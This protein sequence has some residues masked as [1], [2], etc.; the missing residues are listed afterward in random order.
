MEISSMSLKITFDTAE[1]CAA[2]ATLAKITVEENAVEI[3]VPWSKLTMAKQAAGAVSFEQVNDDNVEFIMKGDPEHEGVA[4]LIVMVDIL[5]NDFYH[6]K[7]TNALALF[8]LV[9]GLDP[10][11]IDSIALHG[12]SSISA[13]DPDAVD[14]DPLSADGQWARIRVAS[15]YRPLL[16]SFTYY[17]SIVTKSTPEVYLIDTGVDWTHPEFANLTHEDFWKAA[18]FADYKDTIGHGT[19]LA[20][21]I[22]GENV[23]IARNIKLFSAKITDKATGF[24]TIKEIGECIDAILAKVEVE[25]NVTRI[26]NASWATDKNTYLEAKFQALLDAGVTVVAASGNSGTDVELITPAG[27]A[28][29]ITVGAV[30]RYDIPAGFNNIAPTDSGLT[31]NYGQRLDIFAPGDGVAL[32]KIGGGYISTSGTSYAAAYVTGVAGEIAALFADSVLNPF[33]MEKI[34]DVS[35]KDAILFDDDR[36]SENQNKLIHL[37]GAKDVE[38]TNL[39]LYLGAISAENAQIVLNVNTTVDTSGHVA[40]LPDEKFV[41]SLEWDDEAVEEEYSSFVS[42]DP[43]TGV[44]TVVNPTVA[45]PVGQTIHMVRFKAVATSASITID[46]PWMFFFDI[47]PDADTADTENDI[48]RALA[49]TNS[50]SIFL[51]QFSL[52]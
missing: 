18:K 21:A 27:M 52:K 12:V 47:D 17:D 7:T 4:P 2:F 16:T 8:D 45:L 43:T 30:D 22:G 36:F 9:D 24:C 28:Q 6:V 51:L 37:I 32:A 19:S 35:T 46:G 49:E 44:L 3:T 25:P 13:E 20:S 5:G 40:L 38:A 34:V 42:I 31:T 48:T 10:L 29:V 50:T 39:D 14:I 41:W 23:G 1:N 15:S 26:V 11:E 33:L